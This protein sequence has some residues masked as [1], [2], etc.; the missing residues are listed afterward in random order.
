MINLI[1]NKNKMFKFA[2]KD[3]QKSY[4]FHLKNIEIYLI[5]L[6][7]QPKDFILNKQLSIIKVTVK[8]FNIVNN[9]VSTNSTSTFK[10]QC[11]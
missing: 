2:I 11:V 4:L 9:I 7:N 5:D 1:I 3:E 8:L 10:K 6:Q